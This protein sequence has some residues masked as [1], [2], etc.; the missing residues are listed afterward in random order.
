MRGPHTGFVYV[1]Q[2]DGAPLSVDER[3][4]PAFVETG[5]FVR[6]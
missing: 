6:V 1:F 4:A 3:D 5:Q 2:E